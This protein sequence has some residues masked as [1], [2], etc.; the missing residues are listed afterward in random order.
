M[1]EMN[2]N[3]MRRVDLVCD[4]FD[5]CCQAGQ[6]PRIEDYLDDADATALPVLREELLRVELEWRCRSD[7]PPQVSDYR[8]RFPECAGV[9][10][11]WLSEARAAASNLQSADLALEERIDAV[12][13]RYERLCQAGQVPAL[14]PFLEGFAE[15]EREP[16]LRELQRLEQHYR[17]SGE[18]VDH[19]QGGT[20]PPLAPATAPAGGAIPAALADHPRYRVLKTLGGGGMGTVYLAEHKMMKRPV[21]LKALRPELTAQAGLAERFRREV[22]AAA[23]VTHPNIVAAH[24]ADQAGDCL[25]LV[26][27]Y[28]EGIDLARWL[29]EHGPLPV[30]EACDSVRQ[31]ALGLQ[32]AHEQGMVHR[33]LKP[34]NLMRTASG[35]VKVLDFGLA[36]MVQLAQEGGTVSGMVLGTPDYMAPEQANDAHSADIR[37][38][39]YS[40]G[41]TLYQLL[42]GQVP[43]PGGGLLDKLRRHAQE[44]PESLARL[45]PDLPAGLVR[46]IDRMLAKNPAQRYQTPAEVVAALEPFCRPS[47]RKS[48]RRAGRGGGRPQPRCWP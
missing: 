11:Q 42:S 34:H 8:E 6:R 48:G 38:D 3:A 33:D 46:V 13:L 18:T 39:V 24:D 31:A 37:A 32:Y 47:E 2:A 10:S 45:R 40:L 1:P 26:M 21:A 17:R 23:R 29:K 41:C 5:R 12:C 27:E 30:A 22:E 4:S 15:T 43:F 7:Q 20:P 25:F 35:Q 36:R 14:E 28:V 19:S 9:L 16:L 44:Q